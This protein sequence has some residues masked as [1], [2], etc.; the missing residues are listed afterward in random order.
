MS[1]PGAPSQSFLKNIC[2][3]QEVNEVLEIGL[4]QSNTDSALTEL[5]AH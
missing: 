1:H 4:L 3:Y 5:M 2:I